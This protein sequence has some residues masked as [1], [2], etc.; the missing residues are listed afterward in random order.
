MLTILLGRAG[1]GKT[2]RM[3][4]EICREGKRRPQV[5][6]VPEQASHE[7][8]RRLCARGGDGVSLY[9]EVLSFTRLAS[10][11]SAQAGGLARPVLDG[12][13]RMLL[14]HRAVQSVAYRLK[15]YGRPARRPAFLSGLL[16]TVDELKSY[17]IPLD[18]L[19][20][21]GEEQ[22]GLQ[23]EK[24]EDLALICGAYDALLAGAALDPMD[25]LTRLAEQ[26]EQCQWGEGI[27][28]YIDG[29]TDFTTQQEEV[30]RRLAAR[31][32]RMTVALTCDGLE[33]DGGELFA[34]ARRTA[35]RLMRLAEED[36]TA[37]RVETLG[38]PRRFPEGSALAWLE[39]SLFADRPEGTPPPSGE[40]LALFQAVTPRGEVEWTAAAI[41][42]LLRTG[43]YRLRDI[44][45]A[46]RN[47]GEYGHLLESVFRRYDLPLFLSRTGEILSKPVMTL[48]SC[49]LEVAA[50]GYEYDSVFRLL[51]TGLTD[52]S[53][54]D[55]DLLENYVLKWDIRGSRWTGGD[56]TMHP[57]GYGRKFTGEDH[58]LLDRLNAA[59]RQVT[60]PLERLRKDRDLTGKGQAV[61]LYRYLEE[62]RLPER[63][64][65]RTAELARE[66]ELVLA[67]EYSQLWDILC[68]ALEQC[69]DLLGEESLEREEFA[70]LFRLVLSQYDVGTIPV[71]L[72]RVTAGEMPRI[73]NREVKVLFLLGADDGNLPARGEGSGLLTDEDRELLSEYGLRLAPRWEEKL[74]REMTI[75]YAACAQP[76]RRLYV[77]WSPT[78]ADGGERRPSFLVNRLTRLFPDLRRQEERAL[79]DRFRLTAPGPAAELAG[80]D[81]RLREL[82]K[83]LPE[84]RPLMER[85]ERS[86]EWTRGSL[87]QRAV[88]E[89]Y[90]ARIPMSAS[91]LD[92]YKTCHFSYFMKF[93]LRAE[94]RAP[95]GFHAPE[96]GTFVHAVLE[97]VL[98]AARE[99]GG[100]AALSR[101]RRRALTRQAVERYVTEELGGL[102]GQT[103]RFRYLFQ[104][105]RRTVDQVVDQVLD[106][107]AASDFQP[108]SFELGFG[109]KGDLPPVEVS[110]G[111]VQ[112]RISGFV[113]RVDGWVHN[114]R[115]YLRVVDY[116][117]GRKSFDLT[118]IW[119]G[120]GLQMLLYLFTLQEKGEAL[121]HLPVEPAGV[122]YLPAREALVEGSRRMSEEE[123]QKAVDKQLRRH[124]LVLDDPAVLAAMERPGEGG[125]R[126]LPVRITRTGAI[127]GES[128][129]S[130]QRLG[131]LK[132]HTEKVLREVCQELAAGK[133]T[134]DPFWRGEQKNGCLYCDY[135]AACHFEEGR[136][137]DCRRWLPRMDARR[138]WEQVEQTGED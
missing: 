44:A 92:Q 42:E 107:L 26:L 94:P 5:L 136:G 80:R 99:E 49:A 89:L 8:E 46:A 17:R 59:R 105:L 110:D 63:L 126:F 13:G 73:V 60:A 43:E 66:G 29:F 82:L 28:L 48:V 39:R 74:A 19:A 79:K 137:G 130:A 86:G 121:Y 100:A 77:T 20:R 57:A 133:I 106:E 113:D 4:E 27:D 85:L 47:M 96:Y 16:A 30:L 56:W 111:G 101:E 12:G 109:E 11:V 129:V 127:T 21:V 51:K 93:G 97:Q 83:E 55:R 15:E 135:A 6:L 22:G 68:S 128:L 122:L 7:A 75:V 103:P 81:A 35:R 50:R 118:E 41:R 53:E 33:E 102:E 138:F 124:G 23:G 10:R 125:V 9:A 65:A 38:Q 117:T 25:R 37:L 62:I 71:S 52:L 58:A 90:G 119:N 114:G 2:A 123:R 69:A 131:R 14:L 76:S 116:K 1:S 95:A 115:L 36:G 54:E 61:S 84:Q 70:R 64:T 24:L 67:E 112:V 18:E 108:I 132:R 72:D 31:A 32:R 78:G 104:R 88:S 98:T 120:M 34:A 3:L 40:E 45:V 87:S 91:R 134:A